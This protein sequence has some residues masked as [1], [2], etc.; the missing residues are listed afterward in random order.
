MTLNTLSFAILLP[1]L[2]LGCALFSGGESKLGSIS[3]IE[4]VTFLEEGGLPMPDTPQH[5][6]RLSATK[7][8]FTPDIRATLAKLQE[9]P[10][11]QTFCI[12]DLPTKTLEITYSSGDRRVMYTSD[13]ACAAIEANEA[14]NEARSRTYVDYKLV[15]RLAALLKSK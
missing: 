9:V 1:W 2:L 15:G 14:N 8:S 12:T 5:F 4:T 3:T 6:E 10:Y 11:D 13:Q 7:A